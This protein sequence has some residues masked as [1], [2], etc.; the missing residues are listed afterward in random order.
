MKRLYFALFFVFI[1]VFISGCWE[2]PPKSYKPTIDLDF[3]SSVSFPSDSSRDVRVIITKIDSEDVEALFNIKLTSNDLDHISFINED[4]SNLG[5]SPQI[6]T[7]TPLKHKDEN[8]IVKFKITGSKDGGDVKKATVF[9][10]VYYKGE[11]L[12]TGKISVT[13]L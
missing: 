8:D 2:T 9:L 3:P 4:G 6:A 11:R 1:L 5:N 13:I 7:T 10:E 12:K